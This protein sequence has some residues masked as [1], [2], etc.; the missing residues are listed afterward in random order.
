MV[1]ADELSVSA[2][3]RG[4]REGRTVIK[5][6]G[7]DDPM[8]ELFAGESIIGDTVTAR[9][10]ELRAVVTAGAGAMLRFVRNGLTEHTV[11]VDADPFEATHPVTAPPGDID[12]RWRAELV[13][14]QPRVLTSHI[15][16]QAT[17]EPIPDAGPATVDGGPGGGDDGGCGCRVVSPSRP[18]ALPSVLVA[19]VLAVLAMRRSRR[20][21]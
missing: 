8:V 14:G 13:I 2:I 6:E 4:V 9:D 3:V 19:T 17:G 21:A 5:L 1:Y 20:A 12:D 15:W 18:P 11:M 16:V 7:P 10:A